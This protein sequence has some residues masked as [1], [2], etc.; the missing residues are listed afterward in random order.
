MDIVQTAAIVIGSIVSLGALIAGAGYGMG[1]WYEGK[2]N[3]KRSEYD[4]LESRLTTL[5]NVCD[6]QQKDL[7]VH[8]EDIKRLGQDIGRLQGINE[9]KDKKIKE[10]MDIL[11]GRDPA[12][13]EF[14]KLG[15]EAITSFKDA[16]DVAVKKLESIESKV[17]K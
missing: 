7:N 1:K 4:L 6:Q 11:A 15:T 12:L 10:L 8:V 16:L 14:I 13:T 2:N 9:E 17:S 3:R 5:Q